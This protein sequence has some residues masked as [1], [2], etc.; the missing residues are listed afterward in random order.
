[1][2]SCNLQVDEL[3][4]ERTWTGAYDCHDKAPDVEKVMFNTKLSV[5]HSESTSPVYSDCRQLHYINV[6][7]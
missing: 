4:G 1:M 7:T 3:L 2:L 6:H 5:H